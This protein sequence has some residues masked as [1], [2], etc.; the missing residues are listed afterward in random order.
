M[1]WS[2]ARDPQWIE[3][4]FCSRPIDEY[5]TKYEKGAKLGSGTFGKVY[6]AERTNRES[7]DPPAV[8]AVKT[9][10][11]AETKVHEWWASEHHILH[12]VGGHTNVVR[13]METYCT[14]RPQLPAKVAFV[15]EL[16]I[17]SLR[18]HL[19]HVCRVEDSAA[20]LWMLDLSKA[21]EH[22]HGLGIVHRDLK[23][24]NCILFD[25]PGRHLLLKVADFGSAAILTLQGGAPLAKCITTYRYSAPEMLRGE[26][27]DFSV[28]I[29]S[30]GIVL[31]E[32]MQTDPREARC[33]RWWLA[34]PVFQS[35]CRFPLP[36][37]VLERKSHGL[38]MCAPRTCKQ[39]AHNLNTSN[40]LLPTLLRCTRL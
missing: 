12:M 11:S 26:A 29:W 24:A 20:A 9:C 33:G 32:M 21:L 36:Q 15:L 39:E 40:T 7:T 38:N 5:V 25:V 17:H 28:D 23:P 35:F 16:G 8:Y 3:R 22:V 34:P 13:L 27:Y 30:V 31:Y 10:Q 4:L 2:E 19:E 6:W 18:T 1:A 37:H 14:P